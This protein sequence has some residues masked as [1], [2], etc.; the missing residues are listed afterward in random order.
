[1]G[2]M[3]V[4]ESQVEL[5]RSVSGVL[6][7]RPVFQDKIV[8][9]DWNGNDVPLR[10]TSMLKGEPEDFLIQG[11]HDAA[12]AKEVGPLF[13][14]LLAD[15]GAIVEGFDAGGK[16]EARF[17]IGPTKNLSLFNAI[18]PGGY[19]SPVFSES[20]INTYKERLKWIEFTRIAFL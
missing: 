15:D 12:A 5:L 16:R 4:T 11:A 3:I 17:E 14:L 2:E 1:M 7:F 9:Y 10:D 19:H 18:T 20:F 8:R 6:G 13:E